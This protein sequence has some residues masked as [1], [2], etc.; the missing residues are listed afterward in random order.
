MKK[1]YLFGR[2]KMAASVMDEAKKQSISVEKTLEKNVPAIHFGK[3]DTLVHD[4]LLCVK[5]GAPLL[6]GTTGW[7]KEAP[8]IK[9]AFENSSVAAL[10]A[11]NCSLG[12]SYFMH[13][14]KLAFSLLEKDSTFLPTL[15]DHHHEQKVDAPSGTAKKIAQDYKQITGQTLPIFSSRAGFHPGTH[16][17]VFD[18]PYETLFLKHESR[19]RNVYAQGALLMAKWLEGKQGFFTMDDFFTRNT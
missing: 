4:A 13:I 10:Y 1:V 17:I 11:P 8:C 3:K 16:Q 5:K 18:S 15:Y 12:V 14:A 2:G 19:N 9:T 7:E 6:I